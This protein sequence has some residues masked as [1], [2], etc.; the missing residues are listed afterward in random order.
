[1]PKP[2]NIYP[3]LHCCQVF[4]LIWVNIVH[5]IFLHYDLGP[6]YSLMSTVVVQGQHLSPYPVLHCCKLSVQIWF[7]IAHMIVLH[8]DLGLYCC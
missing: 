2:V 4:V 6:H 5:M 7:N 1:M 8:Y 3:A